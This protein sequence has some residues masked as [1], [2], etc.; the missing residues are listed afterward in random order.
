M[1]LASL[2]YSL[3]VMYEYNRSGVHIVPTQAPPAVVQGSGTQN[4][5]RRLDVYNDV[6]NECHIDLSD[7]TNA[8]QIVVNATLVIAV[9]LIVDQI[10]QLILSCSMKGNLMYYFVHSDNLYNLAST[11]AQGFSAYGVV[12]PN[13]I[14]FIARKLSAM[15][16]SCSPDD[17]GMIPSDIR[18]FSD[19]D[20]NSCDTWCMELWEL[21]M[22]L[23]A[24][25]SW[26][27][28]IAVGAQTDCYS[29]PTLHL[30]AVAK[31]A[32]DFS[33]WDLDKTD[34]LFVNVGVIIAI[35]FVINVVIEYASVGCDCRGF[36][37]FVGDGS[38][39]HNLFI[40]IQVVCMQAGLPI[41]MAISR[42][43]RPVLLWGGCARK[44][45]SKEYRELEMEKRT[46]LA[47]LEGEGPRQASCC[48]RDPLSQWTC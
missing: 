27:Q 37:E 45:V 43:I 46:Q 17:L 41:P 33:N 47:A 5:I 14:G 8:E 12:M 22:F 4:V 38:R 25:F 48:S 7:T 3:M 21:F 32:V 29:G 44:K 31:P 1:V 42:A 24:N 30:E 40:T 36:R 28:A 18:E 2:L 35:L 39:V 10:R 13:S 23:V 6:Y 16:G 34:Q 20:L 9:I 19:I 15:F 26:I 11:A